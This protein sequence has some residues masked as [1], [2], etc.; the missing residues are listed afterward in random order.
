M[1]YAEEADRNHER[2][3]P[4]LVDSKKV[5]LHMSNGDREGIER[6]N[7]SSYSTPR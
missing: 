6:P 4:K 3:L 1:V 5:S 2:K 7:V